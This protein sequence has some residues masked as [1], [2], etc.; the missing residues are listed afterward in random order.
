MA[1]YIDEKEFARA[2]VAF[3]LT[4]LVLAV[5]NGVA[6][7]AA[8]VVGVSWAW[9]VVIPCALF[10]AIAVPGYLWARKERRK[11]L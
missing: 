10:A 6:A 9:V 11:L 8:F 7:L 1:R 5:V 3:Y 2:R 4:L